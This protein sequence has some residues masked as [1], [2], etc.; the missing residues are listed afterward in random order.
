[1]QLVRPMRSLLR[2]LRPL[3]RR[4]DGPTAVEYAIMLALVAAVCSVAVASLGRE[5]RGTYRE[6]S[7]TIGNSG[8]K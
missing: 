3:L 7:K 2:R 4:E 1:M 8:K 5:G 6:V